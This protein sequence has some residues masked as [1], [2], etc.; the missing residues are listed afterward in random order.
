MAFKALILGQNS[1]TTYP[2]GVRLCSAAVHSV[3]LIIT[4]VIDT[5]SETK[6]RCK[7]S[8][9]SE[10]N[11]CYAFVKKKFVTPWLN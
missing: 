11:S 2:F 7:V 10:C 3:L 6:D 5:L 8:R 9:Y 1:R 4:R